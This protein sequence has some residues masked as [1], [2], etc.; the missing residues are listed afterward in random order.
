MEHPKHTVSEIT[1]AVLLELQWLKAAHD[2]R[3]K[4]HRRADVRAAVK[5]RDVAS[6]KRPRKGPQGR[7]AKVDLTAARERFLEL[8]REGRK[9]EARKI[10]PCELGCSER[11]LDKAGVFA[12]DP[13]ASLREKTEP[14]D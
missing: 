13:W 1:D 2:L 9:S 8:C 7:K 3:D 14:K 12:P 4:L 10:M 6:I 11:Y 5:G